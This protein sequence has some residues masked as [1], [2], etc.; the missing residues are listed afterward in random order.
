MAL[1]LQ[2]L[3]PVLQGA[4]DAILGLFPERACERLY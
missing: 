4:P 1:F 3:S 2:G